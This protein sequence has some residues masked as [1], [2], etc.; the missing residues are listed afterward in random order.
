MKLS[1]WIRTTFC[2]TALGFSACGGGGG[3]GSTPA[4]VTPNDTPPATVISGVAAKGPIK[5]G[6]VKVYAIRNGTEDRTAPI[7]QGQT[8]GDGNY[9]VDAGS[10]TGPVV[11]E[12]TGGSYIDEVSGTAVTLKTPLRAVVSNVT[13]G[14]Q[15]IAV[16]PVTE[17][18]YQKASATAPLT[19][20]AIDDANA[21]IAAF[22]KLG[23]IVTTVPKAGS[24][25]EEQKKYAF[26][27]GAFAQLIFDNKNLNEGLE[28]ALPRLLTLIGAEARNGGFSFDTL[29]KFNS[30]ITRFTNGGHNTTGTTVTPV[31]LPTAGTLTL[32]TA[33]T[34]ATIGAI[35]ITVDL[36][37][38]I[39]VAADGTTGEVATGV[40]TI[41]G[42]AGSGSNKLTLARYIPAAGAIPGRLQLN[43]INAAGFGLGEFATIKFDIATG[44]SFPA[45]AGAFQLSGFTPVALNGTVL[46]GITAAPLSLAIQ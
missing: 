22:F 13:T 46:S 42:V 35:S 33:G 40:V 36:P 20:A 10:Y 18:A 11:V 26:I 6:T 14:T 19:V 30:A 27:L 17:L 45:G 1:N 32:G 8:D 16:T 5:I 25:V 24:A 38:G 37:S 31:P 3:G 39:T 7:G 44:S 41:S 2:L 15:T 43:L 28:D 12:V 29:S 9:S 34:A 23:G 4:P 21:K